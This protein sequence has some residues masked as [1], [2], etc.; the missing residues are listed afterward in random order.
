M[1]WIC[2]MS[3]TQMQGSCRL[4]LSRIEELAGIPSYDDG[5]HTF[6][7][8]CI[9]DDDDSRVEATKLRNPFIL[10]VEILDENSLKITNCANIRLFVIPFS[11]EDISILYRTGECNK[12]CVCMTA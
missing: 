10:N 6:F 3:M 7:N 11:L 2:L 12:Q 9:L 8:N 4:N 5:D 1:M